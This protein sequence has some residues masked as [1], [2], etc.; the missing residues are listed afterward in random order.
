MEQYRKMLDM[1]D[2]GE[3]QMKLQCFTETLLNLDEEYV[4]YEEA[5]YRIL[6][7]FQEDFKIDS[8][9]G[10]QDETTKHSIENCLRGMCE[11]H[12]AIGLA[13]GLALGNFIVPF[14]K[15]IRAAL[16]TLLEQLIENGIPQYGPAEMFTNELETT[17]ASSP[18]V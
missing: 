11:A 9:Y 13:T 2:D 18:S 10:I 5:F 3:D 4:G 12:E 7:R 15:E 14:D 17:P 16:K 1:F 8:L 6:N